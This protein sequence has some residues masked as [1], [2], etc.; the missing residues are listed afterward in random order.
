MK[1]FENQENAKKHF[2]EVVNL[3]DFLEAHNYTC[4]IDSGTLLGYTRENRIIDFDNDFDIAVFIEG[5]TLDQI[6]ENYFK[7]VDL[8]EIKEGYFPIL[9]SI[10]IRVKREFSIDIFLGFIYED[11]VYIFPH[12]KG[13]EK[14]V[15]FPIEKKD[16]YGY[17]V[18]IPNNPELIC[19]ET[20]G[21]NWRTPDPNFRYD[22]FV[23][24]KILRKIKRMVKRRINL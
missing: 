11:K 24:N 6:V 10:H 12:I 14:E 8:I 18:P 21:K 20:Y 16:F 5:N 17:K 4:V 19:E 13:L 2:K 22:W 1:K 3:L 23:E 9:H 15:Y 7:L